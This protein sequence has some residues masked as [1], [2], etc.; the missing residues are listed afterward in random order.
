MCFGCL[1]KSPINEKCRIKLTCDTCKG[2]HPSCMHEERPANAIASDSNIRRATSFRVNKSDEQRTSTIVPVWLSSES[3]PRREV[4]TYALLDT[5]SD[6]T[7]IHAETAAA[8]QVKGNP[9]RLSLSTMTS[10]KSVID[11]QR[12]TGLMVRGFKS[13]ERLNINCI[14]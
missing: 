3:D 8:L 7:F 11:S 5:Q 10:E 9:V 1:R 2:Q 12:V 13:N 14:Y 4:L 6:T